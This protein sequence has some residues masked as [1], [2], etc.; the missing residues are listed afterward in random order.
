MVGLRVLLWKVISILDLHGA[1]KDL[2]ASGTLDRED[3]IRYDKC[4]RETDKL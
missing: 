1:V 2:G 4:L 3:Q